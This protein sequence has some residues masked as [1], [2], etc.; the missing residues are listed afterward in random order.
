MNKPRLVKNFYVTLN[1]PTDSLNDLTRFKSPKLGVSHIRDDCC[2][3]Q[4]PL[5]C[6]LSNGANVNQAEEVGVTPLNIACDM[7]GFR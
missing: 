5:L 7:A 1:Y 4:T 3:M 6:L 2:Q